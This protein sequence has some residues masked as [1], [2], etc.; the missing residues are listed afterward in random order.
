MACSVATNYTR[1]SNQDRTMT[2]LKAA[3]PTPPP[4]ASRLRTRILVMG[5]AFA[6]F[7]LLYYIYLGPLRG[8]VYL[9]FPLGDYS[10][11]DVACCLAYA[12]VPVALMPTTILRFSAFINWCIYFFVYVP[13]VLY[14]VLQGLRTD[15][16]SLAS[17]IFASFLIIIVLTSGRIRTIDITLPARTWR[18][19]FIVSALV[20]IAYTLYIFG[21]AMTLSDITDVYGQRTLAGELAEG[22]LA[23]YTTGILSGC[24][25]PIVMSLGLYYRKPWL[26]TLGALGQVFVYAAFAQ[27]STLLSPAV[28]LALWALSIRGREISARGIAVVCLLVALAP[29]VTS[30]IFSQDNAL[31][32]ENVA[33][34]VYMRTFGMAGAITGTYFDFFS[35]HP[36]TF[37]SHI[38]IVG[39]IIQYPYTA[40]LGVVIG[41]FMNL[42]MN[43]NANFWASDGIAA[44]G[45]L[46]VLLIGVI[47]GLALRVFDAMIPNDNLAIACGAVG[48]S[49]MNLANSSFF[50]ALLTGGLLALIFFS[51]SLRR[52]ELQAKTDPGEMSP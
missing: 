43:A 30:L 27:K 49:I 44:A 40:P 48:P 28:I 25:N 18:A 37:Y 7:W 13:A 22:T 47:I 6:Y 45:L 50:T 14:P 34:I 4:L 29:M 35:T 15:A 52:H 41:D 17:A 20:L 32:I 23:G 26:F 51:A 12:M 24:F 11:I 2:Q 36:Q 8:W 21:G 38:S 16:L 33:A 46:G 42:N 10:S 31:I 5:V 19:L 39:K 3:K 1:A 9:G